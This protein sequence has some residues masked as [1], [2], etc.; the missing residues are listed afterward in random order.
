MRE[1]IR[2]PSDIPIKIYEHDTGLS[3]ATN[4]H[5]ILRD[6]GFGGVCFSCDRAV[7]VGRC[8]RVEIPIHS[9]PFHASGT[10]AWCKKQKQK[11]Q[12]TFAIGVEFKGEDTKFSVRMV[13]QLCHIE[14]YK[15]EVAQKYGRQLTSEQAANEWIEQFAQTF[16][17]M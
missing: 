11:R 6:I 3:E 14:H 15:K 13:E 17:K 9:P 7:K 12:D 4:P 16:P 8:I 1:F 5:P 2:H 10:V